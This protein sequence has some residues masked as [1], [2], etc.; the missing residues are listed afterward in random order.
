MLASLCDVN[1]LMLNKYFTISLLVLFI[2]FFVFEFTAIDLFI[3]D[4]FYNFETGQWLLDKNAVIPRVIFYDGVRALF[5]LFIFGLLITLLF[6]RRYPLINNN[7]IGLLVV[8]LS[9]VL[10]PLFIGY[11]KSVTNIP[12]PTDLERYGGSFPYVTVLTDY[13]STFQQS[14][15]I[16]CYPAGHASGGFSLMSLFF[17]FSNGRKKKIALAS[18]IVFGWTIGNYK[19]IIGDHFFSHTFITMVLSWLLIS[20]LNYVVLRYSKNLKTSAD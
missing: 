18:A 6:F 1:N 8:L 16:K 12:C 7:K 3:Q 13:P 20:S 17:L 11:L 4:Y 9:C 19:M 10:V 5:I 2:S 14:G 15:N